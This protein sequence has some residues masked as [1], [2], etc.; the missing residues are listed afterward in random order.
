[1][2][3]KLEANEFIKLRIQRFSSRYDWHLIKNNRKTITFHILANGLIPIVAL[4][5]TGRFYNADVEL[6][7]FFTLSVNYMSTKFNPIVTVKNGPYR[8][9]FLLVCLSVDQTD[10][11]CCCDISQLHIFRSLVDDLKIDFNREQFGTSC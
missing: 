10:S 9:I 7:E 11:V 8:N 4:L 3:C 6:T 2:C 5:W 1:M